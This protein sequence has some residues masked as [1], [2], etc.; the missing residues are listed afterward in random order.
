MYNPQN[1][2]KDN[3][4]TWFGNTNNIKKQLAY[5]TISQKHKTG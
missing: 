3:L 5:I 1:N 4:V 2:N